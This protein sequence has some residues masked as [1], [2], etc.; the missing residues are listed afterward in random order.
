MENKNVDPSGHEIIDV[1]PYFKSQNVPFSFEK[2]E[3][4]VWYFENKEEV[5]LAYEDLEAE[6]RDLCKEMPN[7]YWVDQTRVAL[8]FYGLTAPYADVALDKWIS[9]N[10]MFAEHFHH[11]DSCNEEHSFYVE[12]G[13]N[14]DF[15]REKLEIKR[16]VRRGFE[17]L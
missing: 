14:F 10:E 3:L 4:G 12:L 13:E 9:K 15:W 16:E 5:L 7:G 8:H 17:F 11:S 2:V 6:I 1:T